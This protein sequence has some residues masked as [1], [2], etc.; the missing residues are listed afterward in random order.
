MTFSLDGTY[1]INEN[2]FVKNVPIQETGSE[3]VWQN[4]LNKWFH[5]NGK[6][7]MQLG[8]IV[9]YCIVEP[10]KERI[11]LKFGY[12]SNSKEII[13]FR[14]TQAMNYLCPEN[15]HNNIESFI[16]L[17]VF[18]LLFL[19]DLFATYSLIFTK[20]R[21]AFVI[22]RNRLI[23]LLRD[24]Y[25][26]HEDEFVLEDYFN[27]DTDVMTLLYSIDND[28]IIFISNENYSYVGSCEISDDLKIIGE[29]SVDLNK[30]NQWRLCRA[31][32]LSQE[33]KKDM[34][35]MTNY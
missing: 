14:A 1:Q 28:K 13:N 11:E 20:S 23:D 24:D 31:T 32:P 15:Y 12:V 16:S 2:Y 3:L 19:S 6:F 34:R 9:G 5:L 18:A 8:F 35:S 22:P 7:Y 10:D 29:F 30:N 33:E 27:A 21:K 26:E 4:N 25:L 17:K